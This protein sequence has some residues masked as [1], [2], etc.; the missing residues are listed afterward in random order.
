MAGSAEAHEMFPLSEPMLGL[1]A[2][3]KFKEA[4]LGNTPLTLT[5]PGPEETKV[6]KSMQEALASP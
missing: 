4:S 3:E 1:K 5:S 2:S 6:A